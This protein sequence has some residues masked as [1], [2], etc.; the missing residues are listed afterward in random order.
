MRAIPP[1]LMLCEGRKPRPRKAPVFRPKES[2]LHFAVAKLLREH[3]RP[4]WL[5]THVGH[6]EARDIRTAAKLKRMGVQPGWPDFI[7]APPGGQIHCLELKRIGE[8]LSDAQYDFRRWCI[9]HG[10][11]HC[12][13]DT[14]DQALAAL[15]H[16]GCL[17]IKIGGSR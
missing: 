8:T 17:R 2:V 16:W 5:W 13:A 10:V 1:L 9:S 12:V 11:A 15:D 7:L 14:L 6:G 4:D 3:A